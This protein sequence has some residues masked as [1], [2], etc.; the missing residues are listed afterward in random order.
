LPF[1]GFFRVN[2][3]DL[4]NNSMLATLNRQEVESSARAAVLSFIDSL[5]NENFDAARDLLID[6]MTFK[7][8]LGSR[9]SADAYMKDMKKMK[10]KY[11]IKKVFVD[12]DWV[13][14]F[15]DITQGNITFYSCGCYQV[16]EGKIKSFEVIFD[17][18]PVLEAADKK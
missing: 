17:P 16:K 6:D 1:D 15:Y 12:V 8:V 7:G 11:N 9:D 10:M 4:K 3:I 13:C 14:L 5:N 18:R 2:D